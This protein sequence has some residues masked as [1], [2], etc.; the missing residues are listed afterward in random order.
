VTLIARGHGASGQQSTDNHVPTPANAIAAAHNKGAGVGSP[1]DARD[2]RF[3]VQQHGV[4]A[5]SEYFA[6]L[7]VPQA[8]RPPQP[9]RRNK[10]ATGAELHCDEGACTLE[11]AQR[12]SGLDVPDA[13]DSIPSHRGQQASLSAPP[14]G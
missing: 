4:G 3:R 2:G 11:E 8:Q 1:R 12:G 5:T 9:A 6:I 13:A 14:P 10:I 7:H